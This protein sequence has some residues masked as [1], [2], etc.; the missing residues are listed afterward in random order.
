MQ[1]FA[2]L[3]ELES[4]L[5]AQLKHYEDRDPT[6]LKALGAKIDIEMERAT[7]WGSNVAAIRDYVQ[8]EANVDLARF[9]GEYEVHELDLEPITWS[10]Y[11]KI[12]PK[13]VPV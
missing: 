7:R 4:D 6:I 2:T 9:D 11:K 1:S 12:L 8:E 13:D 5:L 10:N 3:K